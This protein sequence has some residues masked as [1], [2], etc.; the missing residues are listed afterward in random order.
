MTATIPTTELHNRLAQAG[1]FSH[2]GEEPAGASALYPAPETIV[3]VA[4]DL[5]PTLMPASRQRYFACLLWS[6]E[7]PIPALRDEPA[8]AL[9]EPFRDLEP[10]PTDD[11]LLGGP[12]RWLVRRLFRFDR[13]LLWPACQYPGSDRPFADTE[14]L[15]QVPELRRM[16]PPDLSDL[17]VIGA[18]VLDL[19]QT[20]ACRLLYQVANEVSQSFSDFFVSDWDCREVYRLHHHGKV[21]VSIPDEEL[22]HDLVNDLA[23]WSSLIEDCSGYVSASDDDDE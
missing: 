11:G 3:T 19:K 16:L 18:L 17:A 22:R 2:Q 1:H 8:F 21:V 6:E 20:P 15:D 7:D 4:M 10:I 5:D 12:F 14:V 9:P 23:S 13:I